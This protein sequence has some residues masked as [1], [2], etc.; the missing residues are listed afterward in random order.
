LSFPRKWE[1][2]ETSTNSAS[3]ANP[4]LPSSHNSPFILHRYVISTEGRNLS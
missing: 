2:R 1:F 3:L 4:K